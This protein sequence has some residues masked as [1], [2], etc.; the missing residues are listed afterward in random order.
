MSFERAGSLR[1]TGD[2][3][4]GMRGRVIRGVSWTEEPTTEEPATEEPATEEPT[5]EEP[6]TEDP[7]TEEPATE[8]PTT[9]IGGNN[10]LFEDGDRGGSETF[11]GL[12]GGKTAIED[13]PLGEAGNAGRDPLV[14]DGGDAGKDEGECCFGDKAG[15][16]MIDED[17]LFGERGGNKTFG[18]KGG[19]EEATTEE[20]EGE[21]GG[22]EAI[23]DNPDL[24][25]RKGRSVTDPEDRAISGRRYLIFKTGDSGTES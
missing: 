5:T 16:G 21:S 17:E 2:G 25:G 18:E 10:L 3:E 9:E 12:N 8:E 15:R 7:T 22:R 1:E 4:V 20:G 13:D 14:G 23:E 24:L 6:T 19:N 11:F